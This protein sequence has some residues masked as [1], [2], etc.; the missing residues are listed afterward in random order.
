MY[1]LDTKL[2]AD[3]HIY[4]KIE[5]G[6]YGLKQAAVLAYDN[7]VKNLSSHGYSPIPHTIGIWQHATRRTKFCLCVDD[8][9]VKYFTKQD[10]DHLL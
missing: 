8:F 6:M 7:L 3:G 4:I 5:K 9:G 1:G 10:A 2:A